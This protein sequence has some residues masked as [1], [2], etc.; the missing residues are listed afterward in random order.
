MRKK[1]KRKSAGA[2]P[3]ALKSPSEKISGGKKMVTFA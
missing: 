2:A 1:R 3:G